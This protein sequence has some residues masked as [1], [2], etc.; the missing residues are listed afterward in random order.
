MRPQKKGGS[1]NPPTSVISTQLSGFIA[2]LTLGS[3][4]ALPSILIGAT[5]QT[6][7]QTDKRRITALILLFPPSL[8]GTVSKS[9][10]VLQHF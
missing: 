3:A 7:R 9:D 4:I 5:K 2:L 6:N 10:L 8:N 1:T